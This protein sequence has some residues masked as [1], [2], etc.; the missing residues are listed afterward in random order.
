[1][2]VHLEGEGLPC[3]PVALRAQQLL[4]ADIQDNLTVTQSQVVQLSGTALVILPCSVSMMTACPPICLSANVAL[5]VVSNPG[6]W[7][8]EL[9]YWSTGVRPC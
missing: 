4:I 5:L 9:V 1:M 2:P 3:S 7:R 6:N 8:M